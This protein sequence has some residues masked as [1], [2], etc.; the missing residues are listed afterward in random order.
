MAEIKINKTAAAGVET[1]L[2]DKVSIFV[3]SAD[4]KL[5]HKDENGDVEILSTKDYVDN[6]FK[7][8]IE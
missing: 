6:S 7:E 3:D 4:G 8:L 5:K 2:A 1:P